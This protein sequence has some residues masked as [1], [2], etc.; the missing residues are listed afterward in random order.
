MVPPEPISS[1]KKNEEK[2]WRGLSKRSWMSTIIPTNFIVV[3]KFLK[4]GVCSSK[5]GNACGS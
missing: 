1:N 2:L 3:I 5:G 4:W